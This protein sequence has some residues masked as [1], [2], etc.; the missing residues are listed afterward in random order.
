MGR[1]VWLFKTKALKETYIESE[2]QTYRHT[3]RLSEHFF[4]TTQMR[5][6]PLW[7]RVEGGGKY[8]DCW[9]HSNGIFLE[10]K[11]VFW[12]RC[13]RSRKVLPPPAEEGVLI[14]LYR[15]TMTYK[16]P[17]KGWGLVFFAME[18]RF[19]Q[20]ELSGLEKSWF[21]EKSLWKGVEKRVRRFSRACFTL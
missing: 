1:G 2:R 7:V 19:R 11:G 13:F 17:P 15:H 21:F 3:A 20:K 4:T 10:T 6:I 12:E 5:L 16:I 18:K 9:P 8:F 14:A